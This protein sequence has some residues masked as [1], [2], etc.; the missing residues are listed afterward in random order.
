MLLKVVQ[1]RTD[2]RVF[3][4]VSV[5]YL[6]M[7]ISVQLLTPQTDA[8]QIL[9]FCW[10]NMQWS[11]VEVKNS[12]FAKFGHN[13][14]KY[15]PNLTR[16]TFQCKIWSQFGPNLAKYGPNSKSPTFHFIPGMRGS[17]WNSGI[18]KTLILFGLWEH[19]YHTLSIFLSCFMVTF[20]GLFWTPVPSINARE[21]QQTT[22]GAFAVKR[23]TLLRKIWQKWTFQEHGR[24][25]SRMSDFSYSL[26][27]AYPG[28]WL[29]KH[30]SESAMPWQYEI[31]L[32]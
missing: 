16:P 3:F 5:F 14:A 28:L 10:Q 32:L 20:S 2:K 21:G 30:K 22:F 11:K 26:P 19:F 29:P 27:L 4:T 24:N 12:N 8:T 17:C 7:L 9:D 13:L 25:L 18:S 15:C 1:Q 23:V 6:K 31:P